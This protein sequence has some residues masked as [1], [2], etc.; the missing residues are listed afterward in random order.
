MR[1]G[2][3]T[4]EN[5]IFLAPMASVAD[6]AFRR[7]CK[8]YGADGVFTE[9]ISSKALVFG[10][11]KT[12]QLARICDDERPC[13]LQLFGSDPE[14]M[15]KAAKLALAFSPDLLDINMGCPVRKIVSSGDGS[16]L[17]KDPRLA[18][19]VMRSVVDAVGGVCPV[20]VKIRA[21]FDEQ[22][23]N[24]PEIARLAEEAGISAVFV[25][26][27]TREQMYAPPCRPEIIAAVKE[28]VSIPVIGN[29]DIASA[30]AAA[31]ML[32]ETRCD[33]V[34]IG[35]GAL[36]NPYLFAEIR[37]FLQTGKIL[38]PRTNAEKYAD[39]EEHMRFLIADKGEKAA[40]AECRKHLS[41]YI[42]GVRGASALRDEI[43]RT[44]ELEK[45]LFLIRAALVTE[46]N[47][48]E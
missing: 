4:F 38:P 2:N 8:R 27:R 37:S 44:E 11:K 21:G 1:I 20:T 6:S 31:K 17:M 18:F 24:A 15:G 12:A 7:M 32:K 47:A 36:G 23:L 33:G 42:K 30:D 19:Q 22:H 16:A 34:M 46:T 5:G 28:A 45:T 35:R 26:A 3:I 29:G 14:T 10:D 13:G 9:M 43:N 41:A 40:A 25:H 48:E 39:I